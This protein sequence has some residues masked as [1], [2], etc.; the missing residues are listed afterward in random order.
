VASAASKMAR[1]CATSEA[2]CAMNRHE[3]VPPHA[4]LRDV[5]P[6]GEVLR[7][8]VRARLAEVLEVVLERPAVGHLLASSDSRLQLQQQ[9]DFVRREALGH[10]RNVAGPEQGTARKAVLQ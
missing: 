4:N 5:G 10:A 7:G 3:L 6:F 8:S 1:G 9:H 2:R